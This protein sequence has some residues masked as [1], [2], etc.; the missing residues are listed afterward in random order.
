MC[1]VG[2]KSF[3]T[4]ASLTTLVMQ[5]DSEQYRSKEREKKVADLEA[6]LGRKQIGE[7]TITIS[8]LI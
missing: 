4:F 8:S 5:M 6:A 2:S 7:L 3:L 1:S